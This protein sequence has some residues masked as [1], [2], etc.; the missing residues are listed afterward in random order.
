MAY[1]KAVMQRFMQPAFAGVLTTEQGCSVYTA[2]VGSVEQGALLELMLQV[3]NAT[4][5]VS[6]AHFKM[7]GCAACIAT[8]DLLCE[9]LISLNLTQLQSFNAQKL[10]QTLLLPAVK[11][12]CV[13]LA[14]EAIDQVVQA[15]QSNNSSY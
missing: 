3:N 11:M 1:P 8:A 2:K 10:A 7:Y 14:A 5:Q 13:W 4:Q 9:Q 12:H 15:W 6:N